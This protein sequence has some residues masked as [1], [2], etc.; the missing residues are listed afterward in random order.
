MVAGKIAVVTAAVVL[1]AGGT[2]WVATDGF[3][4]ARPTPIIAPAITEALDAGGVVVIGEPD[5]PYEKIY[6]LSEGE[7]LKLVKTPFII[8]RLRLYREKVNSSQ[9]EAIPDGADRMAFDWAD[10]TLNNESAGFG[11]GP[12]W[13]WSSLNENVLNS[14]WYEVR[15]E[16]PS[17]EQLTLEGDWIIREG[18][19]KA[20]MLAALA[21]IILHETGMALRIEPKQEQRDVL[22]VSGEFNFQPIGPQEEEGRMSVYY[23]ASAPLPGH[24]KRI[25]G[26]SRGLPDSRI[27]V[28]LDIPIIS[29]TGQPFLDHWIDEDLKLA[30]D[31]PDYETKLAGLIDNLE[32]Q[33]GFDIIREKRTFSIWVLTAQDPAKSAE[34]R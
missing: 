16:S 22:I 11:M 4:N 2:A 29:E 23:F 10:Q 28:W 14:L 3:S 6:Q 25:G 30:P 7:N 32:K 5:D 18:L 17:I 33:T 31:Q 13:R 9:V 19:S 27:G 15:V 1:T 21:Q 26:S 34:S 8:D 12:S 24:F 20:D